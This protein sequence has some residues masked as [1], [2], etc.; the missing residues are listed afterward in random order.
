MRLHEIFEGAEDTESALV[1]K[2]A[3]ITNQLKQ[4]VESEEIPPEYTV[5][6]LLDYFRAYDVILDVTDL[7]N[8]IKMPPL[9]GVIS[10]I[11]GDSVVFK[12]QDQ[13]D[14]ETPEDES[15]KVVAQMAKSAMKN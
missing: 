2:I 13:D 1:T 5:D 3:A 11:Q 10:N 14:V 4:E 9:K 12:G 8:M 6:D 15:K 7:Y